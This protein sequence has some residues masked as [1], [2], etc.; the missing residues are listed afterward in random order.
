MI[1]GVDPNKCITNSGVRAVM[2]T[3][4]EF[5]KKLTAP[6]IHIVLGI[7]AALTC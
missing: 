6:S 2:I 1:S 4:E 3:E 7:A 5:E